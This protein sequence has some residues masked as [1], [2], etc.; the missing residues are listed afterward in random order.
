MDFLSKHRVYV[1][2]NFK[3]NMFRLRFTPGGNTYGF[4]GLPL[5]LSLVFIFDDFG[6]IVIGFS[7]FGRILSLIAKV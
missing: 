2:I 4:E 5:F 7:C 3:P 1:I 6:F